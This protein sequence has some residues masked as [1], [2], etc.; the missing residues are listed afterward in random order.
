LR[1][2]EKF[3]GENTRMTE[4]TPANILAYRYACEIRVPRLSART[5]NLHVRAL[6]QML[7]MAQTESYIADLPTKGIKQLKEI[8]EDK[9]LYCKEQLFAI[10]T[11]ALRNHPRTGKQVADWLVLAMYSGGRI[12]ETLK[13]KWANVEWSPDEKEWD[14]GRL[15]FP[16]KTVKQTILPH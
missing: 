12:S 8:P 13:L 14:K 9:T 3:L 7:K 11:V 5:I 6:R 15:R 1:Q 2:W 10:G 16:A 4:I